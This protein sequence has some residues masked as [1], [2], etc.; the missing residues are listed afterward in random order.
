[1]P[2]RDANVRT[3]DATDMR[4]GGRYEVVL[5]SNA[6]SPF[7]INRCQ[8]RFLGTVSPGWARPTII[9]GGLLLLGVCALLATRARRRE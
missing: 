1:V 2:V 3:T 5:S 4:V 9:V 8:M 6:T 7:G